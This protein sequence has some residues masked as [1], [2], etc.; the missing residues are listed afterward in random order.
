MTVRSR[1]LFSCD[2]IITWLV[3]LH[4]YYCF[5]LKAS[6]KALSLLPQASCRALSP[7]SSFLESSLSFLKIPVGHSLL[8]QTSWKAL[9]P[10]FLGAT[11]SDCLE[12]LYCLFTTQV[13]Y[14][15]KLYHYFSS[16]MSSS[17]CVCLCMCAHVW[18]VQ[19][20]EHNHIFWKTIWFLVDWLQ[21]W[22]VIV[23]VWE[24]V[25]TTRVQLLTAGRGATPAVGAAVAAA[26]GSSTHRCTFSSYT[27][28][29]F[30][31]SAEQA[32]LTC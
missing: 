22:L 23:K 30:Q 2:Y 5:D 16:F 17:Q 19:S 6:S 26:G 28:A 7:S 9:S 13:W 14:L 29:A 18:H 24:L 31:S 4:T 12:L 8:L 11:R 27:M 1:P 21:W 25:V 3:F 10:S 32:C 20:S 15:H